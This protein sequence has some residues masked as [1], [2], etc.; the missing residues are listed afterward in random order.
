MSD[1]TW[2]SYAVEGAASVEVPEPP[3]VAPIVDAADTDL[4]QA[5]NAASWGDWNAE[6]AN[7]A[8]ADAADEVG[9]A[10]ELYAGG[11]NEAGD[12]ALARAQNSFDV[13]DSHD[14]TADGYYATAG[15]EH[16]S[17]ADGYGAAAAATTDA[18]SYG[19]GSYDT[20]GSDTSASADA[21]VAD[22]GSDSAE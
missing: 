19:A 6:T 1:S 3:G 7:E 4:W 5:E 22:T 17:A 11:F 9:Y 10:Q 16:Q 14:A 18:A 21:G 15:S 2:D 20:S 12:A 13:A 8:T